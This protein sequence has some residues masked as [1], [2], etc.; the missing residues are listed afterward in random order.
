M[1]TYTRKTGMQCVHGHDIRILEAAG[2][3]LEISWCRECGSLGR[4]W[5]DKWVWTK[6]ANAFLEKTEAVG[7][8]D[9]SF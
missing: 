8:R 6:P 9:D 5:K 7:V 1:R 3:E 4:F 2:E